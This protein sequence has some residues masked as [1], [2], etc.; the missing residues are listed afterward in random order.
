MNA[1]GF[2]PLYTHLYFQVLVGIALG[3]LIGVAWPEA[4]VA[5]RPLG[6]GFI[7]TL[8]LVIGQR[9]RLPTS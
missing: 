6:D 1:H 5:L 4:G 2:R 7:S 9:G 8:A 3:V